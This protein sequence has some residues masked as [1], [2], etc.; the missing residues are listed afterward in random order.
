MTSG[1][2]SAST[3]EHIWKPEELLGRLRERASH[4]Y[5]FI[6]FDFPIG[7]PRDVAIECSG[8]AQTAT[9]AYSAMVASIE[10]WNY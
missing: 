10:L 6:G 3:A 2:Y 9:M 7:I 1:E 5:I 4:A 8:M